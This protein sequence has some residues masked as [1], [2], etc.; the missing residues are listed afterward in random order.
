MQLMLVGVPI[1]GPCHTESPF[2]F[3]PGDFAVASEDGRVEPLS[4]RQRLDQ[5][6]EAQRH[7]MHRPSR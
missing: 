4:R 7:S 2:Q 6:Q 5:G 3:D 1:S